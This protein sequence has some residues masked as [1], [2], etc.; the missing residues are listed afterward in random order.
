MSYLKNSIELDI[1][2]N[3]IGF[4]REEVEKRS[5]EDSLSGFGLSSMKERAR[6]LSGSFSIDAK[7]GVGTKIH[8]SVPINDT[9]GNEENYE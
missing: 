8:V 4:D 6:L 9:S 1:E 7:Q 2:D 3:G 5:G